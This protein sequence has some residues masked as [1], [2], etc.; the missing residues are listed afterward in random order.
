MEDVVIRSASKKDIPII[1]DL[2]YELGRPKPRNDSL[3]TFEKLITKYMSD[4]DKEILVAENQSDVVGMVSIVYL[5]RLN[6]EFFEMYIPEL[7]V[8]KNH[9]NR[10][11]GKKLIEA[12]IK[13]AKD[14]KCHR[15]RLESG[16]Q[17]KESHIFYKNLRFEQSSL[18]FTKNLK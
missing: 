12:C 11:I 7:I 3:D 13:R 9:Q 16:N 18:S 8:A 6:Q 4:S 17:R 1:L 2:L 15:I 5:P 14:K 10:G